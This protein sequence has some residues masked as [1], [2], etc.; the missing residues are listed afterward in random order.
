MPDI[1]WPCTPSPT[2]LSTSG[3]GA[4]PPSG[5]SALNTSL[6]HIVDDPL[7]M[8]S[9]LMEKVALENNPR[10]L[11]EL[12]QDN[13]QYWVTTNNQLLHIKFPAKVD[14]NG[15]YGCIGPY[16]NM[17][18]TGLDIPT[19]NKARAQFE[20]MALDD[21]ANKSCPSTAIKCLC[22]FFAALFAF[23]DEVEGCQVC[24]L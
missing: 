10:P 8:N 22:A 2:H 1:D 19:L 13:V 14:H 16:F 9:G 18:S 21:E 5:I 3:S 6:L 15:R 24:E 12:M 20:L 23:F 4:I 11:C 7:A 17:P